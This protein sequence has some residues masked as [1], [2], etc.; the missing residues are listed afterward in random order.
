[1]ARVLFVCGGASCRSQMAAG[2]MNALFPGAVT[3]SAAGAKPKGLDP[4]AVAVMKEAGVDIS[5][6]ESLGLEAFAGQ[7]FDWVVTVCGAEEAC[8][9]IPP[10]ARKIHVGFGDPP[11]LAQGAASREEALVIYRRV[12]DQ[13]RQFVAWY[14]GS[15]L[16]LAD[17]PG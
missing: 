7:K 6:H 5:G 11:R 4:L 12:R 8:P 9:V 15:F 3:A 16:E 14:P 13:I 2:F 17:K 10:G 1:M